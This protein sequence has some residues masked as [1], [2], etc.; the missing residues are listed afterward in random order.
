MDL[1]TELPMSVWT[2]KSSLSSFSVALDASG[3]INFPKLELDRLKLLSLSLGTNS[4]DSQ[5][6]RSTAMS[7]TFWFADV[8]DKVAFSK[9]MQF[10]YTLLMK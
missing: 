10:L 3:K 5:P 9:M 6:T 1:S 7:Q 2:G 8:L 4:G